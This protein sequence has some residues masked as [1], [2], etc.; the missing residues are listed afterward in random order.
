VNVNDKQ[1]LREYAERRYEACWFNHKPLP[2]TE[3]ALAEALIASNEN[4]SPDEYGIEL[5]NWR[6]E[7][8]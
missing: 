5:L 2:S 4:P 1:A 6:V 3:E 7:Q 8:V